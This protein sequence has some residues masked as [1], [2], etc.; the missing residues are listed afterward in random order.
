MCVEKSSSVAFCARWSTMIGLRAKG[1]K[2]A[3]YWS[4][5]VTVRIAQTEITEIGISSDASTT[6]TQAVIR[7]V[8]AARGLDLGVSSASAT[9]AA[10]PP[11]VSSESISLIWA[12]PAADA[13]HWNCYMRKTMEND[14]RQR[15]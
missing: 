3:T 13:R 4:V 5:L 14:G 12:R 8:R 9:P 11:G 6:S 10:A 7:L 15:V 1:A 2:V